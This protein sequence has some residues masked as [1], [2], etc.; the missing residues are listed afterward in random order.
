[1]CPRWPERLIAIYGWCYSSS[2]W[3]LSANDSLAELENK[4]RMRGRRRSGF[5]YLVLL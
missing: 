5:N 2:L 1:M 4:I 3:M